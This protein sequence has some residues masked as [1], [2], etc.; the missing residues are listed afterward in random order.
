MIGVTQQFP[1]FGMVGVDSNN[2]FVDITLDD[3][4]G[5]WKVFYFYPKDFTF[6]CPTEIQQMDRLVDDD[7]AVVGF[8]GDN[9]YCKL[10]WKQSNDLIGDISHTLGADTGLYL[11]RT[12][13]IEDDIE[14][15]ALRATYIVDD[16]NVI[17]SVTVNDLDTGRNVDETIRTLNALRAGGL[18]GCS[19]NPGDSFVG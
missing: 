7:V 17:R 8:S 6:I 9:E 19:W 10:N 2:E 5:M 14:G 11:V 1:P 12:L 16:F 15:V 18:T 3:F 13:G 4:D